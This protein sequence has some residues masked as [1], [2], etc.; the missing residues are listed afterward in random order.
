MIR[1]RRIQFCKGFLIWVRKSV[2]VRVRLGV[3]FRVRVRC[4]KKERERQNKREKKWNGKEKTRQ[5]KK[6]ERRKKMTRASRF[7][8]RY[9]ISLIALHGLL[10][11]PPPPSTLGLGIDGQMPPPP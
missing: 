10:I 7:M 6:E 11:K 9:K 5:R 3:R 8:I 2:R 4:R 1:T